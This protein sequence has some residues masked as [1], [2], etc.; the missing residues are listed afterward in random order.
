MPTNP[1]PEIASPSGMAPV[2]QRQAATPRM[3]SAMTARLALLIRAA[4]DRTRIL[5]PIAYRLRP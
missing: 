1:R 3:P 5:F 2:S 4:P